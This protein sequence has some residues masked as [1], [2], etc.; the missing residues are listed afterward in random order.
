MGALQID[1]L[2]TTFTIQ[3]NEDDAYLEKLLGYY[4][5]LVTHIEKSDSIKSPLHV[6]ILAG[7]MLCDELYKEKTRNAYSQSASD[8]ESSV[9]DQEELERRTAGMIEKLTQALS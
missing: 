6:S 9:Q 3:A 7:I 5:K 8:D 1:T 4:N 2:G